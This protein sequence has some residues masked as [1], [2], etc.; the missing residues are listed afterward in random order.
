MPALILI[1]STAVLFFYL[2]AVCEK[3]LRRRFT[4]EFY[5][6]IVNINRLEFL[7][8]QK[9][10]EDFGSPGEYSRLT[11][12]LKCD[13]L[14]LTYLLKNATN[15]YQRYTYQ[16]RLLILYFKVLFVSLVT[17]HWLGLRENWAVL[18]LTN[19]LQYFA[20]VVGEHVNTVRFGSLTTSDYLLNI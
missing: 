6:S 16:E 14:A 2:Q 13:F 18:K 1:V 12:T 4:Q 10:I 3:L 19:I 17:R 8:V 7:S 15:V 11:V 9:A 5:Q 20:N